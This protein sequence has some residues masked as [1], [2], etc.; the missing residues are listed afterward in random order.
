MHSGPSEMYTPALKA[1]GGKTRLRAELAEIPWWVLPDYL[2]ALLAARRIQLREWGGTSWAAAGSQ[3]DAAVG[4]NWREA[5]IMQALTSATSWLAHFFRTLQTVSLRWYKHTAWRLNLSV[6]EAP[7]L[8]MHTPSTSLQTAIF[9]SHHSYPL[10]HDLGLNDRCFSSL[11]KL[12]GTFSIS[13][14]NS[15]GYVTFLGPWLAPVT[16]DLRVYKDSKHSGNRWSH[17]PNHGHGRHH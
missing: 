5:E 1:Q 15:G 17:Y 7:D 13:T 14:G 16:L 8:H 4:R 11:F 6:L 2:E 3:G 12:A 9:F 10:Y